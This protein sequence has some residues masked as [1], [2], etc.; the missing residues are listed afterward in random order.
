[1]L[2]RQ[3][4]RARHRVVFDDASDRHRTEPLTDIAFVELRGPCDRRNVR[5]RQG[6]K[7]IEQT[8]AVTDRNHEGETSPVQ[9]T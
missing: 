5:R 2:R 6:G 1:M 7:S 3:L 9:Q 4:I 8:G